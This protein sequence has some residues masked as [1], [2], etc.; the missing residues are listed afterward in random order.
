M[1]FFVGHSLSRFS[2][3]APKISFAASMSS[4]HHHQIL[5]HQMLFFLL[6]ELWQSHQICSRHQSNQIVSLRQSKELGIKKQLHKNYLKDLIRPH[7]PNPMFMAL[8]VRSNRSPMQLTFILRTAG[9]HRHLP[10]CSLIYLIFTC[11]LFNHNQISKPWIQDHDL[12]SYNLAPNGNWALDDAIGCMDRLEH[13]PYT[14]LV[15]VEFL[16]KITHSCRIQL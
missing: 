11:G 8:A 2:N 6:F 4:C 5:C 13:V 16:T 3:E 9:R 14:N 1:Q 10:H 12:M 7:N 15:L